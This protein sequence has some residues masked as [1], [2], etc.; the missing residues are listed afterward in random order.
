M[1]WWCWIFSIIV[2]IGYVGKVWIEAGL[3]KDIKPE[4]KEVKPEPEPRKID[5]LNMVYSQTVPQVKFNKVARFATTLLAMQA[6]GNVDLREPTWKT[7]FGSR[8]SYVQVRTRFENAGAFV[9]KT[10][11]TNSP[12]IVNDKGGWYVVERVAAGDETVLN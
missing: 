11:A 10:T 6:H 2:S 4:P 8:E 3:L 12:F 7:H 9:R 1:F 5:N